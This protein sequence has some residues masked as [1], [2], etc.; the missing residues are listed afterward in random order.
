VDD[1]TCITFTTIVILVIFLF[2]QVVTKNGP[3]IGHVGKLLGIFSFAFL[4]N[5]VAT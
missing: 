4:N 5:I 2:L 1:C 3:Y